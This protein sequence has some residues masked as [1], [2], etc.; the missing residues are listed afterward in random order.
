MK[1]KRQYELEI[2]VWDE[3][4][5]NITTRHTGP[6]LLQHVQESGELALSRLVE[7]LYD[8]ELDDDE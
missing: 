4:G 1:T 8:L 2:V 6:D 5:E 3:N 7:R